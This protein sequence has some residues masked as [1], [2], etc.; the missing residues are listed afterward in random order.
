M[1]ATIDTYDAVVLGSGEA[2][3]SIGWHRSALTQTHRGR[4][5]TLVWGGPAPTLPCLP[6]KNFVRR[7][8][9]RSYISC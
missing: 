8:H 4:R 6:S 5:A 2:G 3:K 9:N 7:R 1:A